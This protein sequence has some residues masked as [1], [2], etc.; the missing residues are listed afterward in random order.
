[1]SLDNVKAFQKAVDTVRN[2]LRTLVPDMQGNF[3]LDLT[4]DERDALDAVL[5]AEV[6]AEI[7]QR[8]EKRQDAADRA[9]LR[10]GFREVLKNR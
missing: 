3:R 10:K 7:I 1:M 2:R 5:A 4:P 8:V 9:E 6:P